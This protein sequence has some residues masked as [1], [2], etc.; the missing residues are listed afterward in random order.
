MI[1]A[2]RTAWVDAAKG[3]SIMLVV[4]MYAAYN[5]GEHNGGIGLLHYV[6]GFATPFRMPEL[7]LISGLFLSQVIGRPWLRYADRRVVHYFYFYALWALI[8]IGLKVALFTG[9]PFDALREALL[10]IVHPYGVLWFIY[11]LGVFGLAAKLLWQAGAPHWLV[12]PLAA[13]LQMTG[14]G[15]DIHVAEQFARHFVFFYLGYA[16]APLIF[17]FVEW[18]ENRSALALA[19]LAAWALLNGLL[20]FSP[21]YAVLPTAMEM[22]E[23]VSPPVR[24]ALAI[25]GA[26]ALCVSGALIVKLPVMRWLSWLGAHSLVVYLAFT[27]P[28]SIFRE[29]AMRVGVTNTNL[30]S[31]SVLIVSLVS[32]VILYLLVQRFGVGRFLF[33]RPQWAHIAE[34]RPVGR[35]VPA[36][37]A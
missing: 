2:R 37:A 8:M 34:A 15:T 28:M 20:V 23:A 18:A 14:S 36:R 13:A 19:G 21:G 33:E 16:A 1:D 17:R 5:T 27:I 9:A 3:L 11:M 22:G 25:A 31:V 6:I 32:P 4:M 26:L 30:L 29:A 7:F 10:A 12:L 24:L 35:G